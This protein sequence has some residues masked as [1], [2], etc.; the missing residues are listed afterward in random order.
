MNALI[1]NPADCEVQGVIWFC[2]RKTLD[3]VKFTE[4]LLQSMVNML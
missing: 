1:S 4:D 2:R 3:P